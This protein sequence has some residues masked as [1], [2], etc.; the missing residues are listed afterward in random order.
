MKEDEALFGFHVTDINEVVR[1]FK[2]HSD[3]VNIMAEM[4]REVYG[5]SDVDEDNHAEE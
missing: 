2:G 1:M 4:F 5:E 3:C